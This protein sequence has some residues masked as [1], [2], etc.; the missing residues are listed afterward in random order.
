M[1]PNIKI[2]CITLLSMAIGSLSSCK[3]DDSKIAYG[4]SDIYM[5]QASNISGGVNN[6]Y[7][8]PSGTD[9]S[10][11]N[12]IIDTVNGKVDII[13]GASVSGEASSGG[14]TV[15]IN[16]AADTINQ[17]IAAGTLDS[18][19]IL[20]PASVY[21][22]PS[23]L[24]V[25]PGQTGNTFFLSVDIAQLKQSQY[26]GKV[27]ALAVALANP[28][29]YQLNASISTT[30]VLVNVN[31]LVIGP[32]T[33]ITAQYI[34]NPGNPF[35]AVQ[36]QSGRWGMLADWSYNYAIAN[37]AIFEQHADFTTDAGGSFQIERYGSPE[38]LSGKVWQTITLPAG[39]YTFAPQ[40][41]T[42][43]GVLDPV[44]LVAAQLDSL[45]DYGNVPAAA[46][47][48]TTMYNNL[49]FTL[50]AS[51]KV[52]IGVVVNYVQDEQGFAFTSVQLLTYLKHL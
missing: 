3:K 6:D 45:P 19:T 23:S 4:M 33:D 50:T 11:Y 9:S 22:L 31:S 2:L 47:A 15:N 40:N 39:S 46:L 24:T 13:L 16:T 38:V 37:P 18:T 21:T 35:I 1:K 5:P 42:W 48:Y 36:P 51:S 17:L 41:Y 26:A 8:V 7:P 52:S 43:Q 28:T 25:A 34:Q 12:Y 44:Y 49:N 30:I 14:F 20:M 27:L 10:T 32:S 29:K